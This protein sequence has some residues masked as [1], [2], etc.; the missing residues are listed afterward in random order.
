MKRR[1]I[2]RFPP[3]LERA[4]VDASTVLCSPLRRTVQTALVALQGQGATLELRSCLREVRGRG[5]DNAAA[6]LG[7]AVAARARAGLGA[8]APAAAHVAV[9]AGDAAQPWWSPGA[10]AASSVARRVDDALA[11]VAADAGSPILVTHSNFL[12]RLFQL[13]LDGGGD[14]A[15]RKLANCGVVAF[16]VDAAAPRGRRVS[17]ATLLFGSALAGDDASARR[18]AVLADVRD[19]ASVKGLS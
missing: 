4:F 16:R 17:D 1:C 9:D 10:E 13:E 14:F 5:R 2:T 19:Q 18:A 15:S 6:A 12:R 7:D 8:D 3:R 11:A